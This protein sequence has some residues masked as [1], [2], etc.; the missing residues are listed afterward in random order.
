MWQNIADLHMKK[1][2]SLKSPQSIWNNVKRVETNCSRPNYCHISGRNILCFTLRVNN[3]VPPSSLI[4]KQSWDHGWDTAALPGG[5]GRV[6]FLLPS[7]RG[8]ACR[9]VAG[10][11]A[12]HPLVR[13][14]MGWLKHFPFGHCQKNLLV[15]FCLQ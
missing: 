12:P 7:R 11:K 1:K 2:N 9:A 6:F 14:W 5:H 13:K 4:P 10:S 15:Q 8:G 3:K